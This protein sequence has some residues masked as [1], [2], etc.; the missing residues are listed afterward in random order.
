MRRE[1]RICHKVSCKTMKLLHCSESLDS[2]FYNRVGHT[3]KTVKMPYFCP[4]GRT[5]CRLCSRP[6]LSGKTRR[7]KRNKDMKFIINDFSI[8]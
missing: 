5:H 2:K 8:E 4:D 7:L 1:G 3:N 6:E